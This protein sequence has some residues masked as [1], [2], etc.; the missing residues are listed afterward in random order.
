MTHYLLTSLKNPETFN[1]QGSIKKQF[2]RSIQNGPQGGLKSS[3]YAG[4]LQKSRPKT[5]EIQI[6]VKFT[7]PRQMPDWSITHANFSIQFPF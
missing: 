5:P 2:W 3:F 7:Q 1:S 4:F 6:H